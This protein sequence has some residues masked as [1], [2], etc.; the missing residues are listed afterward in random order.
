MMSNAMGAHAQTKQADSALPQRIFSHQSNEFKERFNHLP[1]SFSHN[2]GEHPLFE[3]PRLR[4]LA[5]TLWTKTGNIVFFT[6]SPTLDQGWNRSK[7]RGASLAQAFS[8]LEETNSWILLKSIQEEPEY[9][10]MLDRC[11]DELQEL[12]GVPLRKQIT[13]VD[14][15]VFIA[16]PN[17]MTPYHIDHESNFLLQIHGDKEVNLF[18]PDDKTILTDPEIENYY[19]GDLSGARY[20]PEIQTKAKVFKITSGT[21]VHH[22]VRAPHWV[23][24]VHSYSVSLSVLFFMRE[25]D[26]QARVYQAN[27]YLRKLNMVPTP[28]GSSPWKDKV[29]SLL[30]S[31]FG[32]SHRNKSDVIRYGLKKYHAP[33][34]FARKLAQ[35]FGIATKSALSE[36]AGAAVNREG[37]TSK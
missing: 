22:P 27:H 7:R 12:T 23:R 37:A 13:W 6:D 5:E 32:R 16:S 2:L 33:A 31:D 20:R 11:L 36:D 25:F 4:R 17:T 28:P 1:F 34:N 35:R 14:A 29:K 30:F 18:D 15:Y 26:L 3:I 9:R 24:N 8:R 10:V 19:I 21:G